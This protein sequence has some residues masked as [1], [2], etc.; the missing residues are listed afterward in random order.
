MRK[1]WSDDISYPER[2]RRVGE[3][4]GAGLPLPVPLEMPRCH[5]RVIVFLYRSLHRRLF[6]VLFTVVDGL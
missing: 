2:D 5:V 4:S 1:R 6:Q 3:L